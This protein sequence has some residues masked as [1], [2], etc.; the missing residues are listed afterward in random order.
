MPLLGDPGHQEMVNTL[1]AIAAKIHKPSAIL[2]I[3]AHW[4]APLATV[5]SALSP[6]LIYDYGGFPKEAY[7]IEYP[8]KGEPQLAH[9]VVNAIR[10][11]GINAA[12]D[13]QRGFDHGVFVPLK[14]MYP[15]ADIPI[16]QLSLVNNLD[17][18]LHIHIG[19][20]LQKLAWDD[21]LVIGSGFSF[22]NLLAFF[23]PNAAETHAK[24]SAFDKWLR[25]TVSDKALP[26]K[27]RQQQLTEWAS[28]PHARFCH[29]REEHLLPLQLCYGMAGRASE[30]VYQLEILGIQASMFV[31]GPVKE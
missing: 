14:I 29:P 15:N 30:R 25:E 20:A 27:C 10:A 17:P 19:K 2:I 16:V 28:A 1:K 18:A 13:T 31:W 22:H 5:T 26:E 9:E 11:Q 7:T 4:E 8:A 24:N 23:M 12:P 21:L 3:S 6:E